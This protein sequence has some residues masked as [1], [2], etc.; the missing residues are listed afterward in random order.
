M[1]MPKSIDLVNPHAADCGCEDRFEAVPP[2]QHRLM[3][4]FDATQILYG[5]GR[6]QETIHA[7]RMLGG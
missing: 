5:E 3:R 4:H 1:T 7:L 6:K 2:E